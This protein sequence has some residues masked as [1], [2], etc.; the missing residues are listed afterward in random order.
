MD[1]APWL[2]WALGLLLSAL[3]LFALPAQV[4]G[5]VLLRVGPGH[6]I[7]VLDAV[8]IV[9]LVTS[10]S[11]F[12]WGLWRERIPLGGLIRRYPARSATVA[13]LGGLGFGLLVAS[14]FSGFFWWWAIGAILFGVLLVLVCV[15]VGSKHAPA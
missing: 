10:S 9:P 4:E 3:V 7:A 5:P 13:F 11:L 14:V 12:F 6:A 1:P 15:Q 8:A 2:R